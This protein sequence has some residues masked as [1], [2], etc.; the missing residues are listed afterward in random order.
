MGAMAYR[1][2]VLLTA[3]S[4]FWPVLY[5]NIKILKELPGNPALQAVVGV[6]VFGVIAYKTYEEE[7]GIRSS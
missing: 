6:I 5:G 2:S 1:V 4:L 7:D 3:L